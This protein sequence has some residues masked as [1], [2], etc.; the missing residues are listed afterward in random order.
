MKSFFYGDSFDNL[1]RLWSY[2]WIR[3]SWISGISSEN[4]SIVA[5]P[6]GI[7]SIPIFSIWTYLLKWSSI[8]LGDV[9]THNIQIILCFFLTGIVMYYFI[10]YITKSKAAALFSGLVLTLSPYHFARSWDHLG[11]ANMQWLVGYIFSII[12]LNQTEKKRIA[13]LSGVL[14][15]L[16]GQFSNYYYVYFAFLFSMIYLLYR[17]WYDIFIV[18]NIPIAQWRRFFTNIGI[19]AFVGAVMMCVQL[20][21]MLFCKDSSA[22]TTVFIRTLGQLFADSA[23]LLNYILPAVYNPVLGKITAPWIGTIFYGENSGAEQTI[24][25]GFVPMFLAFWGWKKCKQRQKIE[26]QTT[27]DN[28]NIGLFSFALIVFIITSFSPYWGS[29]QGFFIPFPSYFLFKIFPMFR[30]YARVA[31]LVLICLCVLSGYGL[32]NLLLNA[33]KRKKQVITLACCF[34]LCI[35]FLNFPPFHITDVRNVSETYAW[36]KQLDDRTVLAEYP[37]EADLRQYLFNQRIHEKPIINGASPGTYADEVAKKIIDIENS[38]TAGILKYLGATHVIIHNEKYRSGE[39][40]AVLGKIPTLKNHPGFIFIKSFGDDEIYSVA[41]DSIDPKDIK[42]EEYTKKKVNSSSFVEPLINKDWKF[43]EVEKMG[44]RIKYL[45]ILPI[46]DLNIN[47]HYSIKLKVVELVAEAKSI[48]LLNRLVKIRAKANSLIDTK[49]LSPYEYIDE[50]TVGNKVKHSIHA[51]YDQSQHIM[52]RDDSEVLVSAQTQD[53]LSLLFFI[54]HHNFIPQQEFVIY[55][56]PGKTNYKIICN[57]KK[58]ELVEIDS[59]QINCWKI[60]ADFISM[61]NL[62]K[63]IGSMLLWVADSSTNEI[64]RIKVVAP[65]GIFIFD[66]NMQ[67]M[68]QGK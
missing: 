26:K 17:I 49:K 7:K 42:V 28:F 9:L 15:G 47:L 14:F 55:L 63:K 48:G 20:G 19:V 35:E 50:Y 61:K 12:Y 39:G 32:K 65:F 58:R 25:L 1:A 27:Y 52:T 60:E 38:T 5:Y 44:Y 64:V 24:Y 43:G 23:T 34:F 66:R 4:I 13:V 31:S 41:A 3:Y 6:Y 62:P 10:L 30:N 40:G 57:T 29:E 45:G 67:E 8:I 22:Q 54:P 33:T 11:L 68:K 16:I 51:Y 2:W 37:I 21:P 46:I 59:N 36:V 18:K 53:P 56:N